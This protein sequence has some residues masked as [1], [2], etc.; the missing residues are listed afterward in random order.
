MSGIPRVKIEELRARYELEPSLKDFYVEGAFDRDVL[1]QCA[2]KL[3]IGSVSLYEIDAVDVPP[4]LVAACN[5]TDGNKQ[6]VI[7][8]ARALADID[9]ACGYRCIVDRDIDHWIGELE[10]TRGLVF[11]EFCDIES[12]YLIQ[13]F[14]NH[15]L[16]NIG[17][18][19]IQDWDLFYISFLSTLK[20]LYSLK[21]A[22][23]NLE[24]NLS[25]MTFERSLLM[26][27]GIIEFDVDDYSKKVLAQNKR[28]AESDEYGEAFGVSTRMLEGDPRSFVRGHD[29]VALIVWVMQKFGG[30]KGLSSPEAIERFMVHAVEDAE[31][32]TL[33][34]TQNA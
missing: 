26:T 15:L 31:N 25:W 5:L 24:W 14:I 11:T 30:V 10:N 7:T 1:E 16:V 23:V 3:K 20:N 19:K 32:L 12:Y 8:L 18:C 2:R 29:L 17:K 27:D 33:L 9:S 28:S 22:G 34:I 6:R 4:A 21:L 13:K